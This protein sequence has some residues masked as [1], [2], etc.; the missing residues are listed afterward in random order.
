MNDYNAT[1]DPAL[2]KKADLLKRQG[3]GASDYAYQS[4]PPLKPYVRQTPSPGP[5]QPT[6]VFQSIGSREKA[7]C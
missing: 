6:K 4:S 5:Q 3:E 1:N 2:T 7:V